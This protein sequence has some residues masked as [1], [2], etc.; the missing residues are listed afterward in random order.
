MQSVTTDDAFVNH[1]LIFTINNHCYHLTS[2]N[3]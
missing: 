1:H 3:W 2:N